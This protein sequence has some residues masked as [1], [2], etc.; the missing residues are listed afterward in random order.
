MAG[1]LLLLYPQQVGSD[2][3]GGPTHGF[4]LPVFVAFSYSALTPS[5]LLRIA[6]LGPLGKDRYATTRRRRDACHPVAA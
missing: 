6:K 2:D 5:S 4:V 1:T 3:V